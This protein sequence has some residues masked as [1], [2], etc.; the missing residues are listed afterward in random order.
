MEPSDAHELESL[1][2][3]LSALETQ[4]HELTTRVAALH[5]QARNFEALA[6]HASCGLLIAHDGAGHAYANAQAAAITGYSVEELLGLSFEALAHPDERARLR[7]NF[8]RRLA[9]SAVPSRYHTCLIHQD[10]HPVIV[11]LSVSLTTWQ[12]QPAVQVAFRDVTERRQA[13][14]RRCRT[15]AAV[16]G[17]LTI[18]DELIA[19]PDMEA[20]LRQAVE[21]PR[22]HL[23]LERCSIHLVE[24]EVMRG[25]YGTS[26]QG[27]TTDEREHTYPAAGYWAHLRQADPNSAPW[28]VLQQTYREWDGE[29]MGTLEGAGETAYTLIQSSHTALGVLYNDNAISGRAL[30]GDVQEVVAVYCSL[31]G[32]IIERQRAE[33]ALRESEVRFREMADLLPDIIFETDAELRLTYA[34]QAAFATLGYEPE[35]LGRGLRIPDLLSEE[36]AE[37]VKERLREIAA[38]GVGEPAQYYIRCAEGR[39]LPVEVRTTV[40]RG[41]SGE[42]VGFRGMARDISERQRIEQAQRMAAVGELGASVAHEFGN[43]LA[44]MRA[45]AHAAQKLGTQETWQSLLEAV[46]RGTERGGALCWNLMRLAHPPA[47]ER[48]AIRIEGPI[49]AALSMAVPE[50]HQRQVEVFRSYQTDPKGQPRDTWVFADAGQME[51]VFLNLFVNACQA[52]PAGGQLKVETDR[53][54]RTGGGGEICVR[55]SDT[56]TGIPSENLP[57]IFEP[58]F[59]TKPCDGPEGENG[60]GLGLSVSCGIVNKHGGTLSVHSQVGRG[61]TFELRLPEYQGPECAREDTDAPGGRNART[62]RDMDARTTRDMDARTTRER[63]ARTT[64][65]R[66]NGE[67]IL[68]VDDDEVLRAGLALALDAEGYE[69]VGAATTAE[70]LEALEQARFDLL[71]TDL[72]L[73]GGGG[74][75]VVAAAHKSNGGL[76]VIVI[77]GK[78]GEALARD[79]L[80]QGA[81]H[82]FLKPFDPTDL[83]QAVRSVVGLRVEG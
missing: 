8:Q 67:R 47:P 66:G 55:I 72:L 80:D 25:T 74:E 75:Q 73:P 43:L 12:G 59:S 52:M 51:Q 13:R 6:E 46:L 19:C 82:C 30:D 60:H 58:F 5:E 79:L 68:V 4:N 63:E 41:P 39:M 7:E 38:E 15:N 9:G 2:Q 57:R 17:V 35:V 71:V 21:L 62:T 78:A 28:G 31:L 54:P 56:G 10:G 70:A 44:G 65:R 48:K 64:R 77:T 83:L 16:R 20:L 37:A 53:L 18:A 26:L 49:E 23:G 34:N 81:R 1:R 32:N 22:A 45:W 69:A 24:D 11:E 33:E 61:S 76:P 27:E 50:L 42:V 3:K 29:G 40:R 36:Q 14:A